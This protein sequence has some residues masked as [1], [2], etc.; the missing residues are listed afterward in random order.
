MGRRSTLVTRSFTEGYS[1]MTRL[2]ETFRRVHF[3][4]TVYKDIL[5]AW[6]EGLEAAWPN[7]PGW[8]KGAQGDRT[9]Y[10]RPHASSMQLS[11]GPNRKWDLDTLDEFL[12]GVGEESA[13]KT[14]WLSGAASSS[15]NIRAYGT[16]SVHV[17]IA[18]PTRAL[19]LRVASVVREAALK[20][21]N[22]RPLDEAPPTKPL[23]VFIG[24]G[25]ASRAW[26]D[27]KDHLVHQHGVQVE[28]YE[29]GRRA[30]HTIRDI[31]IEMLDVST[32]A[33]L[34]HTKED[35]MA[36][37][38]KWRARQ[39]VVHETGLFQG[40][41]GFEKAIVIEESGVEH[42]S[43]LDGIQYLPYTHTITET[44]GDVLA[45]IARERER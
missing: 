7:I 25:G 9:S 20:S 41:L 11:E 38:D 40:R 45:T 3:P 19:V 21:E 5:R 44:Y 36:S 32:M 6:D 35:E 15:V 23:K 12:A 1:S 39:N 13:E 4:S 27:L 28:A 37:D 17:D 24:H 16:A 26:Q 18:M 34:V 33:F 2:S 10:S 30:G 8:Q 29:T 22:L 14:L 42:Y 43:N 31:L